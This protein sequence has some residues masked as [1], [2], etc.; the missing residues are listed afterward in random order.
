MRAY[1]EKEKM[2]IWGTFLLTSYNKETKATSRNPEMRQVIIKKVGD[3]STYV[4]VST[5]YIWL[6]CARG[7]KVCR[8]TPRWRFNRSSLEL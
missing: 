2:I 6:V 4:Q 1:D 3:Y 7:N 8:V 5:R